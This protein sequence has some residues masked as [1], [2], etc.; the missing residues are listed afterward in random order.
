MEKVDRAFLSRSQNTRTQGC[1]IRLI[2]SRGRRDKRKYFVTEQAILAVGRARA[3]RTDGFDGMR[4]IQRGA[5]HPWT[6]SH[7][8]FR[9]PSFTE[10]TP[11][12]WIPVPRGRRRGNPVWLVEK[13]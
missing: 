5:A 11:N 4:H 10:A 1:P 13:L 7:G 9:K 12:L 2:R 3:A 6:T 8:D